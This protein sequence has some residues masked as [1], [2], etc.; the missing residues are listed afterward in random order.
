MKDKIIDK[1]FENLEI[2]TSKYWVISRKKAITSVEKMG[3]E[4]E[5]LTIDEARAEAFA[6]ATRMRNQRL[7]NDENR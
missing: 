5:K 6:Q 4:Q 2:L 1:I 3:I 7:K